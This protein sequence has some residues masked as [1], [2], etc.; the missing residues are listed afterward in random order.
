MLRS[1]SVCNQRYDMGV[2]WSDPVESEHEA[3]SCHYIQKAG[4]GWMQTY[5]SK[6][7]ANP[8]RIAKWLDFMTSDEGQCLHITVLKARTT[9]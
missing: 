6:T 5:V 2:A 7:A 9:T 8:E 4:N 3:C 1:D